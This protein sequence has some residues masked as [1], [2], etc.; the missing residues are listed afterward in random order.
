MESDLIPYL[1]MMKYSA[2]L[3]IMTTHN[4][5]TKI[6]PVY[7]ASLSEK[8]ISIIRKRG[9]DGLVITDCKCLAYGGSDGLTERVISLMDATKKNLA[10]ILHMGTP[11]TLEDVPHSPRI[12][13]SNSGPKST[14]YMI[15][16]LSGK[17]E[18]KGKLP[19]KLNLN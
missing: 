12:I 8:I 3:G 5:F 10:A 1:E 13:W 16:I 17:L 4:K 6:D 15:D 2:L 7:P 18:P 9:F 11:L 19:Y 14:E